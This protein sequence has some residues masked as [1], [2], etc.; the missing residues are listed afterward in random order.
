MV[1]SG[2]PRAGASEVTVALFLGLLSIVI[3]AGLAVVLP[4]ISWARTYRLERELRDLRARLAVLEERPRL[5]TAPQASPRSRPPIAIEPAEP[6]AE[7]ARLP[8]ASSPPTVPPPLPAADPGP[9][10]GTATPHDA[11]VNAEP[12]V[13]PVGLEEAIGGRLML[14]VG[15][16]VLVLGL[17]FFIKYAFD[18][19]WITESMRVGLGV[20]A[21]IA[22]AGVGHRFAG[23]GYPAYGQVLTGGGLA[24]LFLSI[25]AAFS[26]YDLIGRSPAFV[27]LV[28]VTIAAAALADR[29]AAV[30]LAVMGVGGGFATPF[31]VGG[32]TD[33][34]VV[35]FSY[36]AL[37]V[38][39]TLYLAARRDWPV[40]NQVSFVGTWLTILAWA[41][42]FYSAGKWRVTELFLTLFAVLFL[43]IL[44]QQVRRHGWRSL[45]SITLALGPPL[46][47]LSSLAVLDRHG[48]APLVYLIALTLAA[49]AAAARSEIPGWRVVAWG[50]VFPPLLTWLVGHGAERWLVANLVAAIGIFALHLLAQLDVVFRHERSLARLDTVL[51]H[52]N[53]YA[54]IAALYLAL[55]NVS[56]ATAPGAALAVGAG[57]AGLAWIL[58][59]RD[60]RAALHALA[61]ALGAV[62]IAC[63]L[64]LDGPWLTV[65][66]GVEGALVIALGLRLNE[67]WFRAGGAALLAAALLRYTALSLPATPATFA[68]FRD[69]PFAIGALLALV[70]YGVAWEYRRH[71]GAPLTEGV[72]GLALAMLVASSLV[73]V[74]FSAENDLYWNLKGDVSADARFAS[75]L[76]LS[77]IWALCASGFIAAGLWRGYAPIRYLAIGL[78]GLT[79]VKVFLVDLSALGGIYRIL[80]F[81]GVG[82]VLLMVSFAYQR[83][84]RGLR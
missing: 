19:Q 76:A 14:W 46:Y 75:S 43:G 73:V 34:Q 29:Q 11:Q 26:F 56:L 13:E 36:D 28:G 16:V 82:L 18:N 51:V 69:Q 67:G 65:A 22:L 48:V 72:Y 37:L 23:R 33:A 15:T 12:A 27:L 44:R 55:E 4:V 38:G 62:A 35:L 8:A 40:L 5:G 20:A 64:R 61:V 42:T 7:I 50:A 74:A 54:L 24:V 57:H 49:I 6:A 2:A 39:G 66:L 47:H 83:L 81:V 25:Y 53:G 63:A 21:G 78:F 79:V 1:H 31:L 59:G 60:E 41:V 70:L 10:A 30:G 9:A 77:F 58:R 84:R 80:G 32:G 45:T 3:A 71:R 52:L 68:L 17:A